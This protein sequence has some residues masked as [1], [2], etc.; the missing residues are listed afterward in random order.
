MSAAADDAKPTFDK[1]WAVPGALLY[2]CG[3]RTRTV[4]RTESAATST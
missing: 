2:R 1:L 4:L 3:S